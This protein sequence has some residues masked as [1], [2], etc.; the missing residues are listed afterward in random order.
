MKRPTFYLTA[1][2]AVLLSVAAWGIGAAMDTPPSLMSRVDYDVARHAI[3]AEARAAMADCRG[4]PVTERGLCKARARADE[5]V[6]V[7]DLVARYRGTVGAAEEARLAR[8]KA[9]F[10]LARARCD[11]L[12]G[13]R[14]IGCLRAARE[15]RARALAAARQAST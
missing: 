12:E 13:E 8:V 14:R 9:G 1:V 15:D 11:S 10:D 6:K 3:T 5:R 4:V 2:L 7:A